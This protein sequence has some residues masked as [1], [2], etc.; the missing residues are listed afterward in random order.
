MDKYDYFESPHCSYSQGIRT[1]FDESSSD[2]SVKV[3]KI[4][5]TKRV[6]S[7]YSSSDSEKD[8]VN[9]N[10]DISDFTKCY[11]CLNFSKEPIICRYCGN[12]ACKKCLDKWKKNNDKC[13]V[14]RKIIPKDDTV[15]MPQWLR[16]WRV[17]D[18]RTARQWHDCGLRHVARR[19]VRHRP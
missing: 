3:K 12:L 16:S 10:T 1:T 8:L 9:I 18:G 4:K 6:E 11:I 17:R 19:V 2:S 15:R 5:R 7:D 14:C 13:G